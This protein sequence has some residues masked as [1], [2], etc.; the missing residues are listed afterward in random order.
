MGGRLELFCMMELEVLEAALDDWLEALHNCGH[1]MYDEASLELEAMNETTEDLF[2]E[3]RAEYQRR[4]K[5]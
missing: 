3:V 1:E 5:L 4:A 2:E